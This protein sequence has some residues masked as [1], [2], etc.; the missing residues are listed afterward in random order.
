VLLDLCPAELCALGC[1]G[2]LRCEG[3]DWSE[4]YAAYCDENGE[5]VELP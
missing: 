1:S 4:D 3:A 5:L 2:F